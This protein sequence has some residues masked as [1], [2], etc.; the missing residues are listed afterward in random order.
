M[1]TNVTA[2]TIINIV[3]KDPKST[4][5]TLY[6]YFQYCGLGEPSGEEIQLFEKKMKNFKQVLENKK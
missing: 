4:G 3:A 2:E 5:Q 6:D 1:K